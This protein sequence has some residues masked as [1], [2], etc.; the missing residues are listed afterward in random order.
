MGSTTNET[1][2]PDTY[3]LT[4]TSIPFLFLQRIYFEGCR[5]GE[6]SEQNGTF[7]N[8]LPL[9]SVEPTVP[10]EAAVRRSTRANTSLRPSCSGA[11]PDFLLHHTGDDLGH[12]VHRED[13]EAVSPRANPT[14]PTSMSDGLQELLSNCQQTGVQPTVQTG[15]T[16]LHRDRVQQ[17]AKDRLRVSVGGRRLR[18]QEVGRGA[19]HMPAKQL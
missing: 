10:W 6:A 7:P 19:Q 18:G 12:P 9:D 13:R 16:T 1:T 3:Q 2:S 4:K 5:E 15:V 8:F 11:L 17:S 14:I